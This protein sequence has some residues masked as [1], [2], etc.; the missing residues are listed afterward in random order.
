MDY[1]IIALDK[2][3]RV[4]VYRWLQRN[5]AFRYFIDG[6]NYST[7]K[8]KTIEQVNKRI[9]NDNSFAECDGNIFF[10]DLLNVNGDKELLDK[11]FNYLFGLLD[12]KRITIKQ[13]KFMDEERLKYL[14][15]KRV[16]NPDCERC[17]LYLVYKKKCGD[18]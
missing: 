4:K 12:N 6:K 18:K 5:K 10:I 15:D 9:L 3:E 13:T 16:S 14:F 17:P 2:N 11:I 8:K 1:M 7:I